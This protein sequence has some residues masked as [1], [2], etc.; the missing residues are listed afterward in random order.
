MKLTRR[1]KW[2]TG[3]FL[4]VT[5]LAL[6]TEVLFAFDGNTD[7]HPWTDLIVAYVP[8]EAAVAVFGALLLWVPIHFYVRYAR[9]E[10]KIRADEREKVAK[11]IEKELDRRN[12]MLVCK[13][14]VQ[15]GKGCVDCAIERNT[16]L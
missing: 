16:K 7:T 15:M 10:A 12:L 11:K 1:G 6:A 5:G 9:K 3:A 8:W 4:T 2:L 14:G 13:H